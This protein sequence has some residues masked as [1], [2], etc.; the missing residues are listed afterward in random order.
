MNVGPV[1]PYS[2]IQYPQ[3]NWNTS[4]SISMNQQVYVQN[5]PSVNGIEAAKQLPVGK[6]ASVMIL[7]ANENVLYVKSTDAIGAMTNFVAFKM[8]QLN[9]D[10]QTNSKTNDRLSKMENDISE[11]KK[12]LNERRGYNGKQYT[13][14]SEQSKPRSTASNESSSEGAGSN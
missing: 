5:I 7:D 2:G 11:I 14:Y 8:E 10:A 3:F 1:N 9:L 4:T 13:K 12:M 6:N